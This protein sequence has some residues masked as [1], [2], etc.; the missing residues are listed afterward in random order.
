[1]NTSI[2]WTVWPLA[3]GVTGRAQSCL[4]ALGFSTQEL[5][6]IGG[7]DNL[8]APLGPEEEQ[9]AIAALEQGDDAAR[10]C[11]LSTISVWWC[12][13]PGGLRTRASIWRT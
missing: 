11:S 7:S 8:P 1:M 2:V 6:Y 9:R 5:L 12:I 10:S 4:S 3:S 13:S